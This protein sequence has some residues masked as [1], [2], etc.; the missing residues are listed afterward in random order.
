M[1]EGKGGRRGRRALER[2]WRGRGGG[3]GGIKKMNQ[4]ITVIVIQHLSVSGVITS[5][6][7]APRYSYP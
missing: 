6:V 4:N 3:G 7:V 5:L 2:R 1:E